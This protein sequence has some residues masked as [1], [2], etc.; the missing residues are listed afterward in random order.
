MTPFCNLLWDFFRANCYEIFVTIQRKF[1]FVECAN[2]RAAQRFLGMH[3][4]LVIDRDVGFADIAGAN[5]CWHLQ[6]MF[7]R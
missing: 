5:I 1:I 7:I 2:Q 4:P 3:R 6:G